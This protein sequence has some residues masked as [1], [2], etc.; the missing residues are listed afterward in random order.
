MKYLLDATATFPYILY[1]TIGPSPW[2]PISSRGSKI[3]LINYAPF[4]LNCAAII[5]N[6]AGLFPPNM[7]GLGVVLETQ[8]PF[9]IANLSSKQRESIVL[10]LCSTV[11]QFLSLV[12]APFFMTP[13]LKV[14]FCGIVLTFFSKIAAL[15]SKIQNWFLQ[16]IVPGPK[17]CELGV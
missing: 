11:L 14:E 2:T 12:P 5:F 9:P 6:W 13:S 3:D 16:K 15:S 4:V 17:T 8:P 7:A 1:D 10:Q